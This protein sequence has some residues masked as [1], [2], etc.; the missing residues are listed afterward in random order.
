MKHH[1][2]DGL[3]LQ[4]RELNIIKYKF[5]VDNSIYLLFRIVQKVDDKMIE[6]S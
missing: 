5:K 4:L 2:H 1:I 3:T 6:V